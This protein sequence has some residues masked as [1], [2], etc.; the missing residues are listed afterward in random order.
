MYV[1]HAVILGSIL[2]LTAC[3][4]MDGMENY[5]RSKV[6]TA[7]K[8]VCSGDAGAEM[9]G[10]YTVYSP[11]EI[12]LAFGEQR[13]ALKRERTASGAKY[14]SSTASFWNKGIDGL[15][16]F[17]DGPAYSCRFLPDDVSFEETSASGDMMAAP[18]PAVIYDAPVAPPAMPD[19]TAP[20]PP[21][22]PM[23]SP[24][25]ATPQPAPGVYAPPVPLPPV[26][27]AINP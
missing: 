10:Y 13:Y 22:K 18:A 16:E 9:R 27:P 20:I 11:S 3:V 17:K 7:R 26:K 23:T 24:A 4:S 14:K 15:L 12:G 8:M 21:Q 5:P 6:A 25:A 1:R 2:S 19:S